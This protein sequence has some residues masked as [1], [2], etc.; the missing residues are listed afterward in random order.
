MYECILESSMAF[1][2]VN[3]A[4]STNIVLNFDNRRTLKIADWKSRLYIIYTEG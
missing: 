4:R 1:V 3:L 2:D